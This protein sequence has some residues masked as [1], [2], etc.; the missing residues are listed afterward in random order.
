MYT[1][2]SLLSAWISYSI[3]ITHMKSQCGNIF[4]GS[5]KYLVHCRKEAIAVFGRCSAHMTIVLVTSPQWTQIVSCS[6]HILSRLVV[7]CGCGRCFWRCWCVCLCDSVCSGWLQMR[8]WADEVE[9]NLDWTWVKYRPLCQQHANHSEVRGKFG[10]GNIFLYWFQDSCKWPRP[11]DEDLGLG[12]PTLMER[13]RIK[14]V[15]IASQD[16][17]GGHWEQWVN[18]PWVLVFVLAPSHRLKGLFWPAKFLV[19]SGGSR[20]SQTNKRVLLSV[21]SPSAGTTYK[22]GAV[23]PLIR[24][25]HYLNNS[26]QLGTFPMTS[27]AFLF[28]T[29]QLVFF[30][31]HN[32]CPCFAAKVAHG[33]FFDAHLA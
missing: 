6:T 10:N 26:L 4:S 31:E 28:V 18:L 15:N 17:N 11:F 22:V 27:S 8:R 23:M 1:V 12:L 2:T 7:F 30:T 3:Q 24:A 16:V 14:R 20:L 29:R 25:T 5:R 19:S 9:F 33:I 13:A 21:P 32:P